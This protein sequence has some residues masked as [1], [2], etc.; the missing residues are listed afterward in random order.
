MRCECGAVE[1]LSEGIAAAAVPI[2]IVA[3]A[4]AAVGI[5]FAAAIHWFRNRR[6]S[7]RAREV[8]FVGRWGVLGPELYLVGKRVRR[9]VGPDNHDRPG[10][11]GQPAPTALAFAR[12]MLAEVM[13]CHPATR[14]ARAFADAQLEPLPPG[15]FVLSRSDVEAWLD[16]REGRYEPA[17]RNDS[18]HAA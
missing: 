17:D 4:L 3:A 16:T 15:G 14:L 6:P 8:L 2:A 11:R 12:R 18:R 9:L 1:A 13:R 7:T 10:S 5:T